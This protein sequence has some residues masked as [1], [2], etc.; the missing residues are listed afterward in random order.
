MGEIVKGAVKE[1]LTK[2]CV[3]S[4]EALSLPHH[5]ITPRNIQ[6]DWLTP[7]HDGCNLLITTVSCCNEKVVETIYAAVSQK[8]FGLGFVCFDLSKDLIKIV[9]YQLSI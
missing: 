8:E 4:Y 6:K 3:R 7:D 9:Q 1:E 5:I 2:L